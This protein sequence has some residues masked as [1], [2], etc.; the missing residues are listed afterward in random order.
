MTAKTEVAVPFAEPPWKNGLPSF[1]LT[2]E[3]K[4]WQENCHSFIQEHL[5]QHAWDWEKE[6]T[7]PAHVFQT[8]AKH[9]MLIPA[10]PAPLPVKELHE[11]GIYDI[12][13]T[14]VED[15]TSWHN[16]IYGDEMIRS[17]LTGPGGSLTTGMAFGVPP[18]VK[19][20]SEQLK[21]RILPDLLTGKKR[22][23][24][25]ITE[26]DAGSDVANIRTTAVKS[27]DG[28]KY[29]VN[30]TKK[31]IT[32]A[33][34][35]D[36]ACMAVRTGAPGPSGLSLLVVPLKGHKG[37]EMRRLKVSGQISAGTTFIE[38]DDVEVPVENL[39]GK[40]GYGMNYIMNNFNHERLSIAI[41]TTRQAR[42]ALSS[43]FAYVQKREA[44][45]KTLI[46]Q[47]VVRHRLAKAGLLLESQ[48]AWIEQFIYQM[49]K[50]KKEDAD[51]ELGGLTA[52]AKAN[53][54]MVLK[55]CADCAVLLFGG[56][57]YTRSGQG[58]IAE[59]M[60]REV[61]G[62]R[63][64]GGSEDV[65]LDLMVRQLHKNYERKLKELMMTPGSK[66]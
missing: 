48:Q 2:P 23:C 34:W 61:N 56:N 35:S 37:V 21:R 13:G 55:E 43:A 31:W 17:G 65:M 52:G 1:W 51:R 26:P 29:I 54:G 60:W 30:G 42:V 58:E 20:G 47:P 9:N 53:A 33:F 11:A 49:T 10:L 5:T 22:T 25:A 28:K 14:K 38:L 39:I 64:P 45:G 44:F 27:A 6:E 63:I 46:E 40:E 4:Q 18:V 50:M 57:G 32:N 59:R 41:S 62:N 7:V 8:F 15:F 66:L 24:I 3:L 19:Y 36:N 16:Y 12:L